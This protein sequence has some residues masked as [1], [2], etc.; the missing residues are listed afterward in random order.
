MGV[1]GQRVPVGWSEPRPS[2]R[3]RVLRSVVFLTPR[4]SLSRFP[5]APSVPAMRLLA[6][7]VVLLLAGASS[8]PAATVAALDGRMLTGPTLTIDPKAGTVAAGGVTVALADCDWIEPGDGAGIEL[9]GV[10]T[11]RLGL[12]LVDGSWLPVSTIAVGTKDNE[13]SVNG[14]FGSFVVPLTAVRGW[15]SGQ[16]LPGVDGKED[17]VT[18][19][20]GPITGRVEGLVA[21]KLV[22]RSALD[23]EP[24]QL[25]L[26]QVRSV[27]LAVPLRTPKG[28]RLAAALDDLHPPLRVVPVVGGFALAAVPQIVLA[29]GL[30][31]ARL[32]IEGGR[33]VYLSELDPAKVEETGAFGVV[34]PHKRDRNLDDSPLRLAGV[35]YE[36]GLT[37][38]SQAR[39]GWELGGAYS[40]LRAFVGIADLV[41][42]QGDCAASLSVDGMV[43]W[44][45]DSIRGAEKPQLIDLDL[46]GVKK[47]ELRVDYGARYDIADHLVLAD[48]Y[49]I[50]AK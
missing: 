20:S 22:L 42:D 11:K 31:S 16:S 50:K 10:A 29:Q 40:R 32:R 14:A 34:W 25:A 38:H 48:A 15:S 47:L 26:D 41:G 30:S 37:V 5:L 4:R 39:I 35:R 18:L 3:A 7:L 24:L 17:Q 27:R 21:G 1:F 2:L 46:T 43:V 19:D 49:L 12:W 45:K 8:L 23:P 9:P 6:V 33:R 13:L 28:V 44:S 36:R